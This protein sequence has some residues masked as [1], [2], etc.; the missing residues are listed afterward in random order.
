MATKA[1][2]VTTFERQTNQQRLIVALII[3][4]DGFSEASF[5]WVFPPVVNSSMTNTHS[6]TISMQ[7][8]RGWIF[9]ANAFALYL[10]TMLMIPFCQVRQ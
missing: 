10:R 7:Q 6:N 4:K 5:P 9:C 2:Q 1:K 3:E 8:V